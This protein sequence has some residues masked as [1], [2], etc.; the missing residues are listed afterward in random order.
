MDVKPAHAIEMLF[1]DKRAPDL[2]NPLFTPKRH[3]PFQSNGTSY[4]PGTAQSC[5]SFE[6]EPLR[7]K[8][9][10]A[11]PKLGQVGHCS[12][13]YDVY[14]KNGVRFR[15]ICLSF[16]W[17]KSYEKSYILYLYLGYPTK[18]KKKIGTHITPYLW[19]LFGRYS[20]PHS[21]TL[22]GLHLEIDKIVTASIRTPNIS[23]YLFLIN[24]PPP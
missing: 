10:L 23:K 20:K 16:G 19:G 17:K 9:H 5:P 7:E 18:S 8:L 1:Q 24:Q 13:V 3:D 4:P 11:A 22:F 12:E 21:G 14:T 15:S 6:A 2:R